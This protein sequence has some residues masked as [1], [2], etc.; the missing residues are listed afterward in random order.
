MVKTTKLTNSVSNKSTGF[1]EQK[2]SNKSSDLDYYKN[3]ILFTSAPFSQILVIPH[4]K[5][6]RI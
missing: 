2:A 4:I 1:K 6:S 5:K 3:L